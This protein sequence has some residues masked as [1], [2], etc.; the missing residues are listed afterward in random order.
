MAGALRRNRGPRGRGGASPASSLR[1]FREGGCSQRQER[2]WGQR[3]WPPMASD[4]N[5]LPRA[6]KVCV[7]TLLARGYA[8]CLSGSLPVSLRGEGLL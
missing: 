5:S 2:A 6:G 7:W 3:A 4:A 8:Q 1:G